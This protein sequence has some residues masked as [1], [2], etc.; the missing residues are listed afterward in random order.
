MR[1]SR[2]ENIQKEHSQVCSEDDLARLSRCGVECDGRAKTNQVSLQ[3]FRQGR[4][5]SLAVPFQVV[6]QHFGAYLG[7]LFA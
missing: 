5:G 2:L 3:G 7:C 4:Y 1:V 6:E